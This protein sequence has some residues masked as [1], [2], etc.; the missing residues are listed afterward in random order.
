MPSFFMQAGVF[1][2]KETDVDGGHNP[3]HFCI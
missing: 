1:D 3:A 2:R